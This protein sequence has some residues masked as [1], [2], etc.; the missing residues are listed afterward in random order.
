MTHVP[1]GIRLK[2][3][4]PWIA[5]VA[6]AA[7]S[8]TSPGVP[9]QAA[10]PATTVSAAAADTAALGVNVSGVN[11]W[12][13]EWPFVDAFRTSRY[14]VSQRIGG[15]WG[16]G[17]ALSLDADGWVTKLEKDASV[18]AA[19]LLSPSAYPA[20]KFVVTWKGKGQVSIWGGDGKMSNAT[21]NRFEY[22]VG[23]PGGHFLRISETDPHDYVRDIHMW[24]PGYEQTGAAQ[25]FHPLFLDRLRGMK[26]LRF[27]D[28]M[29][30][31]NS[32]QVTWDQYPTERS[33][34]Q[35]DGVAP[36]IMARLA[37]RTGAAPWFTMPHLADDNWIRQF[38]T[39]IRDSVD[40]N[41]KIYIEYSNE[42]WNGQFDQAKWA[43]EQGVAKGLYSPGWEW[44]AK[45]HMQAER[46]V[47][48]FR[49]WRSVFGDSADRRLVRVLATQAAFPAAGEAV[50]A[51]KDAY[52]EADAVAIAPYFSCDGDYLR[53]GRL[54]NPGHPAAAAG[55]LK[56]GVN[57]VLDN[58]QRA[59]HQEI[60]NWIT[61]Y[62]AL[63]D[64]YGLTLL[65]YE[66]GQHLT[67]IAGGE[68]NE[69]V[70][71]IMYAANRSIRMRTMYAQYMSLWR[72]LGGGT[73]ALF[74][75]G[76]TMT[77]W[78]SWGL[79]EYENQPIA[80]APKYLAVD[81]AMQGLGQRTTVIARPTVT[82]MSARTGLAA[83]GN[84]LR[85]TGTNLA[86]TG[87][88]RFGKVR[89]AIQSATATQLIVVV[90]PNL[91]GGTVDVAVENPAG[92]TTPVPATTY[93][94]FPPPVLRGLSTQTASAVRGTE[95]TLTGSALTGATSV[96]L[97]KTAVRNLQLLSPT[98]IRF[99]APP[100]AAGTVDITVTTPYGTS[101]VVPAGRVTYVN[102]PRPVVTG[103]SVD[104]G[105]SNVATTVVISGSD[106]TGTT[107]VMIGNA[108]ASFSVL[109]NTQLRAT[110]PAQA[111]GTWVNVTVVTPGGP[112]FSSN[113]TD[114]RYYAP[115]GPSVTGL[116]THQGRTK[117]ATAVAVTGT[118]LTGTKLVTVAGVKA[119][120]K[121]VSPTQ[122]TITVP[123][124]APATGHVIVTNAGG[125]S[126]AAGSIT[127]FT[128]VAG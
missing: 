17:P 37:N 67:G 24:L 4:F 111:A 98:S 44:Q 9:A 115:P 126:G 7:T 81:E 32:R 90:P 69:A 22:E 63:A 74:S 119:A 38:A 118:N 76:S 95:V 105:P 36:Q 5:V 106:F 109:S 3:R 12:T 18:D 96:S 65:G 41:L 26:T 46:S 61:S 29:E 88:V 28:W 102:P 53:T 122:L 93:T 87:A 6:L 125:M 27:M 62:R 45:L 54:T 92:T 114:F 77:K 84:T 89:A 52:R 2:S 78:G 70:N 75:S 51:W 66:G 57:G 82:A 83:G 101:T 20:G 14:W 73:L 33:A 68:N 15:G 97:G 19:I 117:V 99:T 31:N 120:F 85:I 112:S 80:A 110:F 123:A 30:T 128:W 35:S 49:I 59:L 25:E 127:A 71:R 94:Y 113:V 47:E 103:L 10:L 16:T 108:R 34:R 100:R 42:V 58:C 121:V 104:Q 56:V 86:S 13:S 23:A 91:P 116:S 50:L 60:R 11:D 55:V 107:A 72:E 39:A 8:L 40:P 1:A 124:H 21:A 64:K 79:V 48:I 43:Q